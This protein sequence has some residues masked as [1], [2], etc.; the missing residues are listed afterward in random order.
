MKIEITDIKNGFLVS[1]Y[2]GDS[3]STGS[4][5]QFCETWEAVTKYIDSWVDAYVKWVK[6]FNT[7]VEP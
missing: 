1:L 3:V 4:H 5:D 2:D 7:D 6:V